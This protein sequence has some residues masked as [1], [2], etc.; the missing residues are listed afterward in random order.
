MFGSIHN[1]NKENTVLGSVARAGK[2]GLLGGKGG[3]TNNALHPTKGTGKAT[4]PFGT[5][6]HPN[7]MTPGKK[8]ALD[9]K[10]PA[11][12][13]GLRDTSAQTPSMKP[14]QLPQISTVQRQEKATMTIKKRRQGLLFTPNIS[15]SSNAFTRS[16]AKENVKQQE[17]VGILEL[18][19][20]EYAPPT[21][22][23]SPPLSALDE[24]GCDLDVA[25]VPITQLSTSNMR[26]RQLPQLD[27]GLEPMLDIPLFTQQPQKYFLG[28]GKSNIPRP[29]SFVFSQLEC[30]PV[31]LV[32]HSLY[33]S[34]IPHLKRKR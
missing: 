27:L 19:E 8:G 32:A 12:R 25:L 33:P 22:S 18:L 15:K 17:P 10:Q 34:R 6:M 11:T 23:I 4:V 24:F 16:Q 13:M 21:R 31:P 28:L 30:K 3:A 1:Q 29:G 2:P 14:Q 9:G 7:T 20:P 26:A 5:P